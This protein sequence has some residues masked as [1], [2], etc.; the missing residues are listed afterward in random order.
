MN[1]R[2]IMRRPEML[3]VTGLTYVSQWRLEQKGLF[4]QRVKLNP[5]DTRGCAPVGWFSDE[6][7]EW[8]HNR[9]RQAVKV[10]YR[11]EAAQ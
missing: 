10:A 4:P 6:I 11:P 7:E 2:R 8:V 9:V 5:T 1:E 3:R